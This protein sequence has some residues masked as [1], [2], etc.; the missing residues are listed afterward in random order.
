MGDP[1]NFLEQYERRKGSWALWSLLARLLTSLRAPAD[2]LRIHEIMKN[3]R[4]G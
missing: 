3:K 4:N 2:S 1:I